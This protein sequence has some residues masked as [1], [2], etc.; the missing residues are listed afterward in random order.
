MRRN[1]IKQTTQTLKSEV[2][3]TLDYLPLD[4]LK[5]L[6]DFANYLRIKIEKPNWTD[7]VAKPQTAQTLK[8]DMVSPPPSAH[9]ISPRLV[10]REQVADFKMEIIMEPSHDCL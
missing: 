5:Q 7:M 6:A 4:K 8:M 9:I 3:A 10:H 2:I 1:N